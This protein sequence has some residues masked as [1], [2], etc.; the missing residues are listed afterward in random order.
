MKKVF[1]RSKGDQYHGWGNVIRQLNIAKYLTE[2]K[3]KVFFFVETDKN[4]S[5]FLKKYKFRIVK[6]S[7]KISVKKEKQILKKYGNSDASII[8]MLNPPVHLQK[9]YLKNT[10]KLIVYDDL[11]SGKYISDILISC[12]GISV[13]K[14]KILNK[15]IKILKGYKYFPLTEKFSKNSLS[16]KKK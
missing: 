1:I 7:K 4:L 9:L 6:L 5:S 10:E 3:F 14:N 16:K 12:Q 15:K 11:L 2:K 13:N 8:E